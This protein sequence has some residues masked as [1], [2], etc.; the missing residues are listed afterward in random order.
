MATIAKNSKIKT[1][2]LA[3]QRNLMRRKK[4]QAQQTPKA[5]EPAKST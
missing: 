2:S 1:L 4:K 5:K 3:L